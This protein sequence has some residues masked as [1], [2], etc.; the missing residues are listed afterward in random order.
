MRYLYIVDRLTLESYAK[1]G[2]GLE[3]P[4]NPQAAISAL[5]FEYIS[6]CCGDMVE[7]YQSQWT[8]VAWTYQMIRLSNT[9]RYNPPRMRVPGPRRGPGSYRSGNGLYALKGFDDMMMR[10]DYHLLELVLR[11][12]HGYPGHLHHLQQSTT[13]PRNL[14]RYPKKSYQAAPEAPAHLPDPEFSLLPLDVLTPRLADPIP[15]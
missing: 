7:Y 14:L 10:T 6:G 5:C 9:A 15:H 2:P 4:H 11:L 1:P 12:D 3:W 13:R 8:A